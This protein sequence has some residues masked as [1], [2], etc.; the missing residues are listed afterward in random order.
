MARGGRADGV[1]PRRLVELAALVRI[2]DHQRRQR[3]LDHGRG[4]RHEG[5]EPVHHLCPEGV[6]GVFLEDGG[7]QGWVFSGS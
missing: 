6:A 7:E 1:D 4:G 3:D 5:D 2:R